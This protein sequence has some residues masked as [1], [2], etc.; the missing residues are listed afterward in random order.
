MRTLL[1]LFTPAAGCAAVLLTFRS[2]GIP[3][4]PLPHVGRIADAMLDAAVVR[5]VFGALA[6]V[7]LIH[8][9]ETAKF[10]NAWS[11]YLAEVRKLSSGP[12]SDPALGDQRFVS[13]SRIGNDLNRLSW[14]STTPYLSVL[15]APDMS[16]AR[17]VFAPD[18]SYF[19]LSCQTATANALA[20]N[21]VPQDIRKLIAKYSCL[22]RR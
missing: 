7:T 15:V 1:I 17:L 4:R 8:I 11:S 2:Q 6:I 21:P 5:A 20:Q 12:H 22:H 9:V 10:A 19:W 14:W 13:S 3:L 16:P 18:A